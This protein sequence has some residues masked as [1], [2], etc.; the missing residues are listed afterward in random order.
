MNYRKLSENDKVILMN[1][2][3]TKWIRMSQKKFDEYETVQ[4]RMEDLLK[5]YGMLDKD[6]EEK[7]DIRS[8]YFAI[9]GK[10]N[11]KCS[12]CTMNSGPDVST[13]ED[14]TLAEIENILLPQLNKFNLSKLVITGG[15]PLARQDITD[16]L[17]IISKNIPKH[18]IVLQTNGTLLNKDNIVELSKY[19]GVLEIS[20]ENIFGDKELLN[21]FKENFEIAKENGIIL[22]LSFV[23]DDQSRKYITKAIDLCQKYQAALT[24]RIVSLLGRAKEKKLRDLVIKKDNI[25][26]T[27]LNIIDYIL[28]NNYYDSHIAKSF[29]SIPQVCKTCGA[30]GKVLSIRP[31]GTVFMCANFKSERYGIG[32]IRKEQLSSILKKLQQK[33]D[34][35][36][37]QREFYTSN[38]KRCSECSV[39]GFCP[40]P[41]AAVVAENGDWEEDCLYKQALIKYN[42]FYYNPKETVERNLKGLR[43]YLKRL[44]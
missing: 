37:Y 29:F 32:N 28:E 14:L 23:V 10:C 38:R 25:I 21:K 27:Y 8:V 44:L 13:K 15:E 5:N 20:I 34:S 16:L 26:K 3:N 17:R 9:T 30:F 22:S 6:N 19:V 24:I 41:C 42:L 31:N 1:P 33:M 18:K 2:H 4:E 12:F 7:V 40:G 35:I 11:L 43:D 36:D 39:F